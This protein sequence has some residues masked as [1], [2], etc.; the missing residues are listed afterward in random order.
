MKTAY[1]DCWAGASGDM[2]LGALLDAGAGLETLNEGLSALGLGLSVTAERVLR[3]G[4]AAMKADVQVDEQHGGP[5][6]H[7]RGLSEIRSIITQSPLAPAVQRKAISIF[8]R[9]GQAEAS[10]HGTDVEAVHFHEVGAL[11][12]I[13][14]IVGACLCLADLGVE[15]VLFGALPVGGGSVESA[16]GTL[17]VPAPATLALFRGLTVWD[18]GE[19]YE[20]VTPTGAAVLATVGRQSLLWP[21]MKIASL[22]VGAGTRDTPRPNIL[23]VA[24][25]TAAAD[26]DWPRPVSGFGEGTVVVCETNLDDTSGEIIA[27][28]VDILRGCGALDAWWSPCGMK[29]GRPGVQVT[30]LCRPED[31]RVLVDRAFAELPTLGIRTHRAER[32]VL[33]R[34]LVTV[35]TKYGSVGVKVGRYGGL[36]LTA[37]PEFEDCRRLA[38]EH[39]VPVRTVIREAEAASELRPPAREPAP[40]S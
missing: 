26:E 17:P 8:E 22:G 19:P 3:R 2:I 4:F 14:D 15:E 31:T 29:K 35:E 7:H 24:V 39:G 5:G 6:H 28:G 34:E 9:L 37:A 1:F 20:L 27:R 36:T 30:F 38:D 10:V 23:R 11:D 16:H 18:P 33:E 40:G 21:A 13:G 25:G 12:A 32:M